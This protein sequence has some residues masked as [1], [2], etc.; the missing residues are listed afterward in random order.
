MLACAHIDWWIHGKLLEVIFAKQV[1]VSGLAYENEEQVIFETDHLC[2]AL[3]YQRWQSRTNAPMSWIPALFSTKLEQIIN[4]TLTLKNSSNQTLAGHK[5]HHCAG[6][7]RFFWDRGIL[8]SGWTTSHNL[9]T[10]IT[11]AISCRASL[12]SPD[13]ESPFAEKACLVRSS[14]CKT[15]YSAQ[16]SSNPFGFHDVCTPAT[17]PNVRPCWFP[18]LSNFPDLAFDLQI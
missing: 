11:N 16:I 2:K 15:K 6:I 8:G 13:P 7:W 18:L 14:S 3:Y 1:T 10:S 5:Y 4:V 12:I 9:A 17:K